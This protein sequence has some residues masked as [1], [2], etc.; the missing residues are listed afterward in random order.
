MIIS[1][2]AAASTNRVIGVGNDLPWNLP[3]DMK[4]FKETTT[5]HCILM[6]RKTW[7]I[8]G[9]ALPGRNS[10][11][12]SGNKQVLPDNTFGFLSISEAVLF[13]KNS[14]EKE[15]M[16]IGGGEIYAHTLPLAD[17]IYLTHVR[18]KIG[19]GTAFRPVCAPVFSGQPFDIPKRVGLAT[20]SVARSDGGCTHCW[21][22]V[23]YTG[24]W[25]SGT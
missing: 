16:V 12:V 21:I 7:N 8:L 14:G 24:Q 3:A 15:L 17:R 23:G 5:G 4:F 22:A 1:L 2:I 10:L 13:A 25:G 19:N 18:T 11:V 6:G 9:K 20:D